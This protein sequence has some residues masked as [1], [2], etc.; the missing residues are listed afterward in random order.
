ML[1]YREEETLNSNIV[2]NALERFKEASLSINL[3]SYL[4]YGKKT[5]QKESEAV[6]DRGNPSLNEPTTLRHCQNSQLKL[7]FCSVNH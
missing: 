4:S 6:W 7:V 1:L 2:T 3:V 5:W